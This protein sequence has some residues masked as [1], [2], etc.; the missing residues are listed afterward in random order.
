MGG[1]ISVVANEIATHH[2]C[3]FGKW[4][5]GIGLE[6]CG[7]L[8]SYRTIN[9]PHE[10]IHSLA[11][12]AVTAAQSGDMSRAGKLLAEVDELSAQVVSLLSSIR[13]EFEAKLGS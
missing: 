1:E 13:S 8:P 12:E 4:Y 10:R 11:K 3:R 9:A 5:E 7:D 6:M 2:S